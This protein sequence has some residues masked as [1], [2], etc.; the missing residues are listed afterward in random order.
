[1]EGGKEGEQ[2]K[3]WGR[4]RG[5]KG[6]RRGKEGTPKEK[7]LEKTGTNSRA[8]RLLQGKVM[9][10]VKGTTEAVISIKQAVD[11][12][13]SKRKNEDMDKSGYNPSVWKLKSVQHSPDWWFLPYC[14]P[15][16]EN[17]SK[18]HFLSN[19][20]WGKKTSASPSCVSHIT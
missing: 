14:L 20:A 8:E 4:E 7:N 6:R 17:K 12:I 2:E 5:K 13:Q 19:N 9:L 18:H 10:C 11:D 1:M 3:R 16:E 15:G